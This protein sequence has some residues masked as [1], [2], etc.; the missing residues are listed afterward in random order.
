METAMKAST[1]Q[2]NLKA[3]LSLVYRAVASRANLPV[4]SNVLI[5]AEPTGKIRLEATNLEIGV[6]AWIGAKVEQA[7]AI[8]IPAKLLSDLVSSFPVTERVELSLAEESQTLNVKCGRLESNL[9]GI[10]AEDFPVVPKF[11]GGG[12][13]IPG[14]K[15]LTLIDQVVFAAAKD[16]AR[17][18]LTGVQVK[19]EE[20]KITMAAADGFRLSVASQNGL[21]GLDTDQ[22]IIP[23]RALAEL[24]KIVKEDELVTVVI[25]PA[26]RQILFHTADWDMTSQLIEG[27]FPDYSQIIPKAHTTRTVVDTAAFLK[28]VKVSSLFARDSANIVKLAIQPGKVTLFATSA[29]LGD[30]VAELDASVDGEAL[31]IAFNCKYLADALN[32][33]DAAQVV[34]ETSVASSPGLFKPVGDERFSCT[35]MPMHISR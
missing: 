17:P 24:G 1:L 8:T 13:E 15:L 35:I 4:L 6:V 28:A 30:N 33:M 2:E 16:E 10:A 9:K 29:E 25:Q 20:D 12:V 23:A 31:E 22:V 19:L 27:N 14:V 5:A 18:I 11:G 32:V 21:S 34:I 3:G 7:G 26:R